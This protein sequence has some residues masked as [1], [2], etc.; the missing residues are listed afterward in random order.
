MLCNDRRAMTFAVNSSAQNTA[1][2]NLM[3]QT[4]FFPRVCSVVSLCNEVV[5]NGCDSQAM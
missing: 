1:H 2:R 5:E 3:S 4:H